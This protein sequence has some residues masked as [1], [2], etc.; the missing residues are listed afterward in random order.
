MSQW[1]MFKGNKAHCIRGYIRVSVGTQTRESPSPL[2]Q[3][4][5]NQLWTSV[6]G[7]GAPHSG[8]MGRNWRGSRGDLQEWGLGPV[9]RS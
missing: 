9:L 8:E 3:R 2:T 6:S 1:C 7:C 4:W 5:C